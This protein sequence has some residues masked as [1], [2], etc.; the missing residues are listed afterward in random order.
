[1]LVTTRTVAVCIRVYQFIEEPL[2]VQTRTG[3]IVRLTLP[4]NVLALVT[5]LSRRRLMPFSA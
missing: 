4:S 2:E 5:A 3:D 1:M